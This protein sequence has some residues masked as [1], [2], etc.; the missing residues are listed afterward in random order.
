M[1]V[2]V[3]RV[4]LACVLASCG[5]KIAGDDA[6][7]APEIPVDDT[8]VP[9]FTA[10]DGKLSPSWNLG[11]DGS[12]VSHGQLCS[13]PAGTRACLGA[14]NGCDGPSPDEIV[15]ECD[16]GFFSRPGAKIGIDIDGTGCVTSIEYALV[17]TSVVQCAL[18]HLATRRFPC[19]ASTTMITPCKPFH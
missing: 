6:D 18:E 12:A 4:L 9:D 5:G 16:P 10:C 7:A 3:A 1:S 8:G 19:E 2:R 15:L 14:S 17:D 13:T 11:C